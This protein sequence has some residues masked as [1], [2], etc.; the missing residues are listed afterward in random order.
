MEM[1]GGLRWAIHR[2]IIVHTKDITSHQSLSVDKYI[3][4]CLLICMRQYMFGGIVGQGGTGPALLDPLAFFIGKVTPDR[5]NLNDDDWGDTDEG[6]NNRL[7]S[8]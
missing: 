6:D 7:L 3:F 4:H 8:H 2:D 1:D 5:E